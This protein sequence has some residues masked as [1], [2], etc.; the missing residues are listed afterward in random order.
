MNLTK[1]KVK[2]KIVNSVEV[3]SNEVRGQ[4]T[5]KERTGSVTPENKT[6]NYTALSG[7]V[8]DTIR[9]QFQKQE[10]PELD[11]VRRKLA[12][13]ADENPQ[14]A[15]KRQFEYMRREEKQAIESRKQEEMERKQKEE[16]VILQKAREE[17]QARQASVGQEEPHGKAQRGGLFARKKKH[18]QTI[19]NKPA[20]GKQ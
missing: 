17:E 11:E 9:E 8:L 14:T 5:G 7:S 3:L 18:K 19:E 15:I 12:E 4:I 13:H 20:I 2:K 1:Q 16:E 10:E 6:E